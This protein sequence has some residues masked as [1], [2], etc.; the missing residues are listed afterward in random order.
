[1]ISTAGVAP[2]LPYSRHLTVVTEMVGADHSQSSHRPFLDLRFG[3]KSILSSCS[4]RPPPTRCWHPFPLPPCSAASSLPCPPLLHS[5][6]LLTSLPWGELPPLSQ[7]FLSC[8]TRGSGVQ[9]H[10]E[11]R[12]V[13]DS[14]GGW[15]VSPLCTCSQAGG[16]AE[17]GNWNPPSTATDTG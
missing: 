10:K 16:L 12:S 3:E 17:R 4:P 1:M 8:S 5:C 6:Y 9:L 14:S 2:V 7:L 13:E 15:P 11:P